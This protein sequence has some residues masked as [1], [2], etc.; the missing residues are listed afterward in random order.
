MK[1]LVS[2]SAVDHFEVPHSF[3][4]ISDTALGYG[5]DDRGFDSWQRLGIFLFTTAS[6]PALGPTQPPIQW[7][8]G[9]FP[10]SKAAGA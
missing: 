10:G 8:Q 7:V 5:L 3:V 4:H 9:A 2:V 1:F 6:R